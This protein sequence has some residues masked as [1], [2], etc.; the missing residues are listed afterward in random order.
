M[1]VSAASE[2]NY[3]VRSYGFSPNRGATLGA[4]LLVFINLTGILMTCFS[5]RFAAI[6]SAPSEVLVRAVFAGVCRLGDRRRFAFPYLFPF[7]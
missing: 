1:L 7:K 6:R 4:D 3:R 5:S 2:N